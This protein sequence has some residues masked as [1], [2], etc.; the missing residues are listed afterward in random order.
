MKQAFALQQSQK[1]T[2]VPQLQ[3]AI[4]LLQMSAGELSEALQN[5]HET[6][7]LLEIKED[8][9]AALDFKEEEVG[10]NFNAVNCAPDIADAEV[11]VPTPIDLTQTDLAQ[12]QFD[13][14]ADPDKA[15]WDDPQNYA[16]VDQRLGNQRSSDYRQLSQNNQ[17]GDAVGFEQSGT[18]FVIPEAPSTLREELGAQAIFLF[19]D[20][21]ERRIAHH[22]IQ[23]INEA[24]YIDVSLQD[25][26]QTLN[27]GKAVAMKDIKRVLK[28]LQKLD[29]VGVA[30]RDPKEC[31]LL[32]LQAKDTNLPGYQTARQIINRH[33]PLLANKAF[34]NLRKQL[35]VSERELK[36]AVALI[37]QLNPH[38]GYSVGH[39]VVDYIVADILVKK[40][41]DHWYANLNPRVLPKLT[42]NQDYQ[43][44]LDRNASGEFDS[45]KEQLQHARWL[46]SNLEKR[47]Q[48]IHAVAEAV[49]ERQQDFFHFGV[50]KMKPL[51]LNDIARSLGIHESTVSRATSGKYLSAP[52]GNFELKYFFS[53]QIETTAGVSVS[54][55]AIQ[56]TIKHIV[57]SESPTKPVSDEK[58]CALLAKKHYKIARR[59]VAKYRKKMNIPASSKRKAF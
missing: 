7:P 11:T 37:Q 3:Q 19:T 59:T 40:Q 20:E 18:Q 14:L 1:L 43:K 51:T 52:Q 16:P 4:R 48:T 29:P 21:D 8:S 24:G 17:F 23:N 53:S 38:P 6:N 22:L 31:L 5:A 28:I 55:L 25:I 32:Q 56:S 2:M 33:L 36:L 26:E 47:H 30:A 50:K 45:M 41:D 42:I 49:V 44:L 58:M 12:L 9:E 15:I 57:D 27:A 46:I 34:C 10:D 39:S 35:G 13:Q 54:A